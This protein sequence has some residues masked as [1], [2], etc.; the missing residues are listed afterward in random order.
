MKA[1]LKI[2]I[3]KMEHPEDGNNSLLIEN[4]DLDFEDD[5]FISILGPSAAG[6]TTLLRIIAGIENRFEGR[7]LLNGDLINSPSNS[8]QI[9]FQNNL[10]FPWKT[11]RSNLKFAIKT[12]MIVGNN[13]VDNW[14][15][16]LELNEQSKSYPKTLSGGEKGRVAFARVFMNPPKVLLLDEPFRNLDIKMKFNLQT[17]LI[18]HLNDN[19][20][21]KT[22]LISHSINDAIYLSDSIIVVK[23][24]PMSTIFSEKNIFKHK[25]NDHLGRKEFFDKIKDVLLST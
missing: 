14:L 5:D 22:I 2:R 9:V 16:K 20:N 18:N 11:V 3:D 25:R 23:D 24:F 1:V 15:D 10:L 17:E 7:V 4:I 19:T 12:K 6:K 13:N 21:V 8:I